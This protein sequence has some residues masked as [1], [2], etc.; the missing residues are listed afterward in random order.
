M[1]VTEPNTNITKSF[2]RSDLIIPTEAVLLRRPGELKHI[3][4]TLQKQN[5]IR[6]I[7]LIGPG[8][9]GKTT[10]ARQYTHQEKADVI[11]EVNAESPE[12]L[13]D[14]FEKLAQALAQTAQD[15]NI[16]K[17][18]L[19]INNPLEREE[20]IISFVKERL[21][22]RSSW[23]LVF[24]NMET[25]TD[26][27]K[28]FPQ[29]T[30][31]WG[32]GQIILT[33][34]DG[35]IQN[36]KH[37][38]ATLQIEELTPL[39]KLTLFA[40]IMT[41]G[42]ES[43]FPEEKRAEA[44]PFLKK[45]PSYPLDVSVAAYYLKATNAPFAGYIENINQNNKNFAAIQTNLL[46]EAGSYTQ[47]RYGILTLS[48]QRLMNTE[49]DFGNLLFF[50]SLLNSQNIP[51]DLLAKDKNN[52]V[53]DNFIFNLKKYSLITNELSLPALGKMISLHRS[54]Q[55]I[56][57]AYLLD[58]LE[59]EKK[60]E[61]LQSAVK[62]IISYVDE[63]IYKENLEK[64]AFL[65]T[66]LRAFLNHGK[67]L[68]VEMQGEIQNRLGYICYHLRDYVNGKKELEESFKILKTTH[69]TNPTKVV[70]TLMYLAIINME[71][72]NYEK[73]NELIESCLKDY[74][75]Y[76]AEI[77]MDV[78]KTFLVIGDVYSVIGE[79]DKAKDIL[80]KSLLIYDQSLLS[81]QDDEEKKLMQSPIRG[82]TLALLGNVYGSLGDYEK[83]RE[84]LEASLK[85]YEDLFPD[86]HFDITAASVL[87][88]NAYIN[89]GAYERGVKLLE[90]SLASYKELLSEDHLDLAWAS[91]YLGNA[92]EKSQNLAQAEKV[93]EKTLEIHKKALGENNIRSAWTSLY[94]GKNYIKLGKISE[95]KALLNQALLIYEKNYGKDHIET[96]RLLEALGQA[97]LA[98]KNFES[99]EKSFNNAL[100]IFQKSSHTDRFIILEDLAQLYAEQA[101]TDQA[102]AFLEQA[103][104]I[105]KARFPE[106]SPH[107]MR[108]QGKLDNLK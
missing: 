39:Q 53:V 57:L 36:N 84:L 108:I 4:E 2:I 75:S 58:I 28:H 77:N 35:T 79:H 99:A 103:L 83:A 55:S 32:K 62:S 30:E 67:L 70:D 95:G 37:I 12:G 71:L 106:H 98:E 21:K 54:T 104:E 9:A 49:Q 24:D 85:T 3:D 20:K 102:T 68:D 92:Y 78:A 5:G 101:K 42:N 50:V 48:L 72:G 74:K 6:S 8:G 31:T 27:Q 51:R 86:H 61:Y 22:L 7:A 15:Q 34:R 66:H 16:L 44:Q 90:R 87:L 43:S 65:I 63:V 38:H 69:F 94:L 23:V 81:Q 59:E 41:N 105:V 14:S 17:G 96:G 13:K 45:I 56:S 52:L 18:F 11:W 40:K 46:K 47:T 80:A 10:L 64:M 25:F 1:Q 107:L 88:G 97:D 93:L 73:A 29:D 89:L 76:F 100:N 60:K 26:I 19:N 33:T 82:R 91:V